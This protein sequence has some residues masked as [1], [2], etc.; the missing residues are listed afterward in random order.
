MNPNVMNSDDGA[1]GDRASRFTLIGKL[2]EEAGLLLIM[3]GI[4]IALAILSPF[5]LTVA[6]LVNVVLTMSVIGIVSIG[7]TYVML[8]GGI[9]LSVGSTMALSAV[10]AAT[11]AKSGSPFILVILIGLGIGFLIGLVN[12]LAITKLRVPPLIATLA[13]LSVAKGI[14]LIYSRGVTVFGLGDAVGWLGRGSIGPIPVPIVLLLILYVL[15]SISLSRTGF[16]RKVYAVGG[17]ERAAR[18]VGIQ[19]ERIKISVYILSSML[20]SFGGLILISRL[21]S[22]PTVIGTGLELETIAA[23]VI[24]GTSLTGGKGGVWGTLIGVAIL[25]LIQNALNLLNVSPY[26]TQLVQGLVIFTAVAIDMNRR[27][28]K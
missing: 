22:A 28:R 18:I 13:M 19:V 14:Q 27:G 8:S 25:A 21:D 6:N 16:G 26:F 7:M 4:S 3:I 12:G 15:A 23:V 2:P 1:S 11:Y 5:F 9:D 24:G 17:N 10:V 20:A